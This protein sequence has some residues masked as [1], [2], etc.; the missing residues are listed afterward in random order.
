ML[1]SILSFYLHAMVLIFLLAFFGGVVGATRIQLLIGG[2]IIWPL[3]LMFYLRKRIWG[4]IR[5]EK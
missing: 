2:L 4:M 1:F 5:N 3:L